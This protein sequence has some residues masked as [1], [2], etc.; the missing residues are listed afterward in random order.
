MF[1]SV[2]AARWGYGAFDVCHEFRLGDDGWCE[3]RSLR[4][5]RR[6]HAAEINSIKQDDFIEVRYRDGKLALLESADFTDFL[7]RLKRLNPAV[8]VDGPDEWAT[9]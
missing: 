9:T 8:E 5:R 2:G 6:L 1:F 4:R 7:A 3:F